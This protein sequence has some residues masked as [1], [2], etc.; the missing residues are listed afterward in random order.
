M[1]AGKG[2]KSLIGLD[3]HRTFGGAKAVSPVRPGI[4]AFRDRP[5]RARP[6]PLSVVLMAAAMLLWSASHGAAQN[7]S[8]SGVTW[9]GS[10]HFQSPS[11]R[12]VNIQQA[13]T[14]KRAESGFYS[15]FGPAQ[16]TVSNT[17]INDNR[18]NY[19]EANSEQG[20]HLEIVNRVGDDIGKVSNVTGSINTGSTEIRVEGDSNNIHAVNSAD[21][22]GCLDGSINDSRMRNSHFDSAS[23]ASVL[24]T[25][26]GL[27]VPDSINSRVA[28]GGSQ[29][30][31]VTR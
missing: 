20:G 12:S 27:A 13:D 22:Q 3:A 10:W 19:I 9:G 29:S 25:V 23:A 17:T 7:M 11:A 21:S 1:W 30:A 6:E 15:S 18:S 14:I 2:G 8:G 24:N 16:T 31:C 4:D 28:A 5:G 26:A